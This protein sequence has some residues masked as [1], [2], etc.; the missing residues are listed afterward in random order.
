MQKDYSQ[1]RWFK[2][3]SKCGFES[4]TG[5]AAE[6]GV[7]QGV[8]IGEWKGMID[9]SGFVNQ[10]DNMMSLHLGHKSDS[11]QLTQ[12]NIYDWVIVRQKCCGKNYWR[13]FF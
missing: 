2:Y 12:Q 8:K 4:E 6:L 1:C 10:Y 11:V 5:W 7:K 9:I 13:V 3:F